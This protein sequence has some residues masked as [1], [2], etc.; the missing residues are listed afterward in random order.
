MYLISFK[1]FFKPIEYWI[2]Y[3]DINFYTNHYAS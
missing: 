2:V 1:N 3:N